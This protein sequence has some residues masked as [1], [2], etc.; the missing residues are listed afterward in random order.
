MSTADAQ[1][2]IG[3]QRFNGTPSPDAL[4]ERIR[5]VDKAQEFG[6]SAGSHPKGEVHPLA[7]ELLRVAL[8]C[9][10]VAFQ[11]LAARHGNLFGEKLGK[12]SPSS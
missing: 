12:G 7:L 1:V 8:G 11:E 9:V 10:L 2:K 4:L 6:Y 5:L 3:F